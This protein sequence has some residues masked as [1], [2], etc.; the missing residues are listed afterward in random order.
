MKHY[1]KWIT[2]F[3]LAEQYE[4]AWLAEKAYREA[5]EWILS[6][7]CPNGSIIGEIEKEL[8]DETIK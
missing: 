8:E 6:G 7:T 4:S 5:L 1:D 2:Q 3:T